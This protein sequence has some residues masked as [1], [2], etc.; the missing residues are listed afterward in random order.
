MANPNEE[1]PRARG[2]PATPETAL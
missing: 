2:R 1:P